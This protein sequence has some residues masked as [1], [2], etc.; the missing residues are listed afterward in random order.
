MKEPFLVRLV[1]LNNLAIEYQEEE[2]KLPLKKI[3]QMYTITKERFIR[4]LQKKCQIQSLDSKQINFEFFDRSQCKYKQEKQ[5]FDANNNFFSF[6]QEFFG[7][8]ETLEIKLIFEINYWNIRGLDIDL[9]ECEEKNEKL[10]QEQQKLMN[11]LEKQKQL[12]QEMKEDLNDIY[13]LA[14]EQIKIKKKK[15]VDIVVLYSSPL[16]QLDNTIQEA[17]F[18]DYESEIKNI[19]VEIKSSGKEIDYEILLATR[20]NLDEAMNWNPQI[21]HLIINGDY[22]L[23]SGYY[24][25]IQ[26]GSLVEKLS[27]DG[28]IQI[29]SYH[30]RKLKRLRLICISSMIAKDIIQVPQANDNN[31]YL[32]E[33]IQ[34]F[35]SVTF[36]GQVKLFNSDDNLGNQFWKYFY[37]QLIQNKNFKDSYENAKKN[38]DELFKNCLKENPTSVKICCCFHEHDQECLK[39]PI[40]IGYTRSHSSHLKCSR[41]RFNHFCGKQYKSVEQ[42]DKGCLGQIYHDNEDEQCQ[43]IEHNCNNYDSRFDEISISLNLKNN[44]T[45]S[46][47]ILSINIPIG[48]QILNKEKEKNICCCFEYHVFQ[49]KLNDS[50]QIS[51]NKYHIKQH[52][53]S[54]KFI[55]RLAEGQNQ[56][57]MRE[58]L[59]FEQK[60]NYLQINKQII[61]IHSQDCS[62]DNFSLLKQILKKYFEKYST[63]KNLDLI[64][65]S[66]EDQHQTIQELM[67]NINQFFDKHLSDDKTFKIISLQKIDNYCKDEQFKQFYE[68][69]LEKFQSK[70]NLIIIFE[71]S[72]NNIIYLK[73]SSLEDFF[74]LI[75]YDEIKAQLIKQKCEKL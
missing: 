47:E 67:Q 14:K 68:N 20:D 39:D 63:N 10:N 43:I 16:I 18:I 62:Q 11:E 4:F 73:Q 72:Y 26:E 54:Q 22:D 9:L 7:K 13:D 37:K 58:L 69:L 61:I 70:E 75:N 44:Q 40:K 41:Q 12:F 17:Q 38:V 2:M 25:E 46:S 30:Q 6:H 21:L 50:Q 52:H 57:D 28:L 65:F 27:L 49:N 36:V 42:C 3:N 55:I 71:V 60:N 45:L 34:N 59:S 35:A 23:N 29:M 48:L 33:N 19:E 1:V 8:P 53:L 31:P 66:N 24:F 74:Q 51:Q 15:E 5:V 56:L 32:I 64:T